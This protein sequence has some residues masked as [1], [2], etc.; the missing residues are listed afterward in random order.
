MGI[1]LASLTC[2]TASEVGPRKIKHVL[3][4]SVDGMHQQDLAVASGYWPLLRYNPSM[5]AVGENPFR[6]DSPRPTIPFKAY[7][8]NELRYHALALT[9]PAE[10]E[11]L[12]HQ[13]QSDVNDKYRNYEDLSRIEHGPAVAGPKS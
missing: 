12:L 13:A 4:L 7:A 3:L 9:R 2:A 6:L 10:A 1:T 8:Y 5:I 11:T